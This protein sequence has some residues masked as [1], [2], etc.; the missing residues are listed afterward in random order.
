MGVAATLTPVPSP[1]TGEGNVGPADYATEPLHKAS[2]VGPEVR[3]SDA[4]PQVPTWRGR[5]LQRTEGRAARLVQSFPSGR[6]GTSLVSTRTGLD[7]P[8]NRS[9][10]DSACSRAPDP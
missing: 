5:A 3:V 7:R 2:A 8:A 6:A 1:E 10:C 9:R 4:Q